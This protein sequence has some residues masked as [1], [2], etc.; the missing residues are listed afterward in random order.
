MSLRRH[1][2]KS[3]RFVTRVMLL[4]AVSR[5]RCTAGTFFDGKLGIWAFTKQVAAKRSSARRPA[6]TLETKEASV[7]KDT[8]REK[9]VTEVLPSIPARWP[10]DGRVILQQDNAP[11]HISPVDQDL[12]AAALQSVGGTAMPPPNSPALNYCGLG[13]FTAIQARQREKSARSL[14]EAIT[15][16]AETYWELPARV[17]YAAF[18]TLQSSM[19]MGIQADGPTTSSR[20]TW[21]SRG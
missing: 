4:A 13:I 10:T 15:A 19:D 16:T 14:D 7:T 17:L 5:P 3:K 12:A 2:V 1:D 6:G 21:E 9:L 18:L 20:R 8:Y 11:A